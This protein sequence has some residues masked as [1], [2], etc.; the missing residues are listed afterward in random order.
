MGMRER[1]IVLIARQSV[2]VTDSII[3]GDAYLNT[4]NGSPR[5]A[6]ERLNRPSV[7]RVQ[8]S[9]CVDLLVVVV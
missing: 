8:L 2:Q 7:V 4:L 3:L 6:V 9:E 5:C 1:Q